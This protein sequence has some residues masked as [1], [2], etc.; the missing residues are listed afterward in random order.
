MSFSDIRSLGD[1]LTSLG[2]GNAY[3]KPLA[4]NDN[5]KQGIYLTHSFAALQQFPFGEI[6]E[7]PEFRQPNFKAKVNLFW[8]NDQRKYAPAP[9]AQLILYSR[10][11]EVRLSGFMQDCP[12]APR[13]CMNP[14]PGEERRTNNGKDGRVL[15]FGVT[16]D[17][18]IYLYL[19]QKDTSLARQIF[20]ELYE[21]D[22]T[23]AQ[24]ALC[25]FP[26]DNDHPSDKNAL[27][28]E[29]RKIVKKGWIEGMRMHA[30]GSCKPYY[31]LN[32][33]GYTLE[34]LFGIIPNGLAEPDYH[35]W[36]LKAYKGGRITLMTPEP[37]RGF[38]HENGAKEFALKYGHPTSDA[39]VYFT[40][41]H[42]AGV[43]CPLTGLTLALKGYDSQG[44]TIN[45]VSGGIYLLD[46]ESCPVAIWSF[47]LLLKHWCRK[48]A[49]A[50]YV[51]YNSEKCGGKTRYTYRSPVYLGEG[52][53]FPKFLD[54]ILA[55]DV[56]YDP[57]IKVGVKVNGDLAE[58]TGVH[59]RSQFRITTKQLSSLYEVFYPEDVS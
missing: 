53:D 59:S 2:V 36:E 32:A 43:L 21:K 23:V 52:T 47:S 34:A 8:I 16:A 12:T 18:R 41:T 55:G 46:E 58:A 51:Y 13:G 7:F 33:G 17:S 54:A 48:H 37:D 31:A 49:H 3:Y 24:S 6:K 1:F 42:K 22:M 10:Y 26:I 56:L 44:E 35:G 28:A 50:C 39:F 20:T 57:G 25:A 40:G 14:V 45:D 5:S 15:I 19:A 30:D 29:L 38:Y 27:L 9:K 11:P 4:E